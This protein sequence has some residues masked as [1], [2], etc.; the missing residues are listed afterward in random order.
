MEPIE[1]KDIRYILAVENAGSFS[2]AA[3]KEY[4]SQPALSRIVKK[5]EQELGLVIFDRGSFPLKL[6]PEGRKVMVYFRKMLEVRKE[7][8][9][10]CD[11]RMRQKDRVVTIGAPSYFCRYVLPPIIDSFRLEH[12]DYQIRIIETN[13][14]ELREF[15]R[16][17]AADLGISVGNSMP[18]DLRIIDLAEETIVLA[19]PAALEVNAHDP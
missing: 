2:R 15:L 17:G 18:P 6:T 8:E 19:V 14:N 9:E 3:E 11:M 16:T 13:D 5:V 7:L 4:I 10:Y 12:P 1:F